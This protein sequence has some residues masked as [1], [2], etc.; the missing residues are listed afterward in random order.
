MLT[1][2]NIVVINAPATVKK[3]AA[4][5]LSAIIMGTAP[6]AYGMST[7]LVGKT[8]SVKFN[9]SELEAE[10]GAAKV[11]DK[12]KRKAVSY[13]MSDRSALRY[14]D[15]TVAECAADLVDQ[16]VENADVAE[17]TA[18][19]LAQVEGEAEVIQTASLD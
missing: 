13:C 7:P 16:F 17:L 11:Y 14:L 19:H 18:F 15:Q 2:R 12:L 10:D 3:V 5:T 8:V 6:L 1:K 9:L 4:A